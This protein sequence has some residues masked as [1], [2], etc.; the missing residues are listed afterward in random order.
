MGGAFQNNAF[1]ESVTQGKAPFALYT[2]PG[3]TQLVAFSGLGAGRGHFV[4][5]STL[6]AI[7]GET[8]YAVALSG[9]TT[10]VGTI[11][12]TD[13]VITATNNKSTPQTVICADY[14]VYV[15]ESGVLTTFS[16]PDLPAPVH[17]V[18][19]MDGYIIFGIRDG[20]FFISAL[21]E[22]NNV[23][24]LDFGEAQGDPDNGVR[25]FVNSRELFYFGERSLEI[26]TNTGNILF[27]FER[28]GGGFIPIGC[29][30]KLTPTQFD[31]S[32]M[33]VDNFARVVHLEGY[34]AVRKSNHGVER[35]IQRTVDAG[36]ASEMEAFT[37]REGGHEFYVLSGPDW[38]WVY[39]AA[40]QLWHPKSSYGLGRSKI[41]GYARWSDRHVVGDYT[42]VKLHV[43][44][45]SAYDEAGG[46]LITTIRSPVIDQPGA[47]IIWDSVQIDAQMGVGRGSVV[48]S[49][50]PKLML[51]WSDD[52]GVTWSPQEEKTLGASGVF[53]GRMLFND[54]GSSGTQ[55]RIFEIMISAPVERCVVSA[56]ALVRYC[57]PED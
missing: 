18:A 8:L 30:A 25:V 38:T 19:F 11:L 46:Y 20:R 24:A 26:Y 7:A 35:D 51:H 1:A 40:T 48:H 21:K 27:P 15:L 50:D 54:L 3:L 32:V 36:R 12:G 37:Y 29:K 22:A 33:W 34:T 52:A 56:Q 9:A 13:P 57:A 10:T 2:D 49:T 28:L 42:G 4:V 6:Y 41:R 5:G 31:N 53:A 14:T 17:S 47:G 39:D 16:D 55:G 43:M 23:S 45:L 44:S